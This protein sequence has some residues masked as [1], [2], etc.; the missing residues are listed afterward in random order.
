MQMQRGTKRQLI[1]RLNRK[2]NR[3]TTA[4]EKTMASNSKHVQTV[5][6]ET[7]NFE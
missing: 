6:I 1:Y 2:S 5:P 7:R 4:K 3:C